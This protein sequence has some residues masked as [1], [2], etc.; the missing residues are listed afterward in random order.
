M[1]RKQRRAMMKEQHEFVKEQKLPSVLTPVPAH[2]WP[3]L[4]RMPAQIWRSNKYM[5]Q[6]WN[7]PNRFYPDLK[8]LSV[9]RVKLNAQGRWN[10]G[11]AWDE[12]Q[13]IKRE[14]GFADWYAVEVYPPDQDV[15][16]V[17]NWRHLWMLPVPL[18]IGWSDR[19]ARD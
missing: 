6:L 19:S 17:A 12:L 9:C 5:A 11:I 2:E 8:R 14:V 13:A 10:D 15:V 1:N 3:H 16:N 4:S 18:E 7:E